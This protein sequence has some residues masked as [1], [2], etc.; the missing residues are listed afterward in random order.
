MG[1][2]QGKGVGRLECLPLARPFFLAPTTSNYFPPRGWGGGGGGLN[3]L[4]QVFR[5][6]GLRKEKQSDNDSL[7]SFFTS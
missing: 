4:F 6:W 3:G 7:F 1:K 5:Q 2:G